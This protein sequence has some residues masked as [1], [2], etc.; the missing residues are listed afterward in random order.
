M[1]MT[2]AGDRP[3]TAVRRFT[4][5][6]GDKGQAA[7]LALAQGVQRYVDFGIHRAGEGHRGRTSS[8]C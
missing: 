4:A 2:P 3:A 5:V 6:Y 7:V 1:G 8:A